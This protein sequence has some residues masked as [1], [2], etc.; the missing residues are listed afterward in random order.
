[1]LIFLPAFIVDTLYIIVKNIVKYR[2]TNRNIDQSLHKNL[3]LALLAFTTTQSQQTCAA[4]IQSADELV[5]YIFSLAAGNKNV[6]LAAS[7]LGAGS[8]LI[9]I[10]HY[11]HSLFQGKESL[12]VRIT[13]Q[14]VIKNIVVLIQFLVMGSIFVISTLGSTI[15]TDN[16]ISIADVL[17]GSLSCVLGPILGLLT[18]TIVQTNTGI[19]GKIKNTL[20][21]LAQ[22]AIDCC[23]KCW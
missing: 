18:T 15:T 8:H 12:R 16:T 2:S 22:K 11:P 13:S 7:F 14:R 4:L 19:A 20:Y 6:I 23:K 1:M 21:S 3:R 5:R 10:A 17:R 9:P